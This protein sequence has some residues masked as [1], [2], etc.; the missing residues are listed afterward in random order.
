MQHPEKWLTSK[1]LSDRLKVKVCTL[2]KW[3]YLGIGPNYIKAG[4]VRRYPLRD[5]EAW[6]RERLIEAEVRRR[7]ASI[8]ARTPRHIA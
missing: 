3:A 4:G 7:V 8:T 2:D 5:V 6:E 1:E